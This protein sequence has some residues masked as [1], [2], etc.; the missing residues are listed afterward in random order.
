MGRSPHVRR[1][2]RVV[3]RRRQRILDALGCVGA[4]MLAA[5]IAHKHLSHAPRGPEPQVATGAPTI[6]GASIH[7]A[8]DR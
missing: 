8:V 3:R 4:V 6:A 2:R 5:L 1:P 7:L